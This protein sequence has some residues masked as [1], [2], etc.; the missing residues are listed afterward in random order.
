MRTTTTVKM[1]M[2]SILKK[3]FEKDKGKPIDFSLRLVLFACP[4]KF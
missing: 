3:E 2:E 1:K 4:K